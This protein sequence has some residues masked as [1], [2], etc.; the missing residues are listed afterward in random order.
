MSYRKDPF[1]GS[2]TSLLISMRRRAGLSIEELATR[3]GT[4]VANLQ[5]IEGGGEPPGM[6]LRGALIN[7]L[8][9]SDA[10]SVSLLEAL[11]AWSDSVS[12]ACLL[13]FY[14]QRAGLT[15][16]ELAQQSGVSLRTLRVVEGG[17]DVLSPFQLGK[18]IDPLDLSGDEARSLH[19]WDAA[20]STPRV[21][22]ARLDPPEEREPALEE[23]ELALEEREPALEES[24]SVLEVQG[25]DPP[26]GAGS[27][28]GEFIVTNNYYKGEAASSRAA[29][30]RPES[31]NTRDQSSLGW[32]VAG[33]LSVVGLVVAI[34]QVADGAL[35]VILCA[36]CIGAAVCA[37]AA[38][39]DRG[40]RR[41]RQKAI[42][43][44]AVLVV[45]SIILF[46][47]N[48]SEDHR[49]TPAE[50]SSWSTRTLASLASSSTPTATVS[51]SVAARPT[52]I[53]P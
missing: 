39:H 28:S 32:D 38:G 31:T 29:D 44:F 16:E 3:T 35:A 2:F 7:A 42:V 26:I 50:A 6:D 8:E 12:Y 45:A 20:A 46:V 30:L 49:R 1:K 14:Q 53:L 37:I 40:S 13:R 36:T 23:R 17:G 43:G 21:A 10:D 9:L 4:T 5:K 24:A 41:R 22:A 33:G 15:I 19:D 34:F 47:V 52:P 11:G 27:I 48:G 18:L 51:R 25:E